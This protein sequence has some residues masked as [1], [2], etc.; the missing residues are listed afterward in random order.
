M[1]H[2]EALDVHLI[3]HRVRPRCS[4]CTIVGP[5]EVISD[6]DAA[7]NEGRGVGVVTNGVV[8]LDLV[9]EYCRVQIDDALDRS[10][11]RIEQQLV[12]IPA[13]SSP[14]IPGPVHPEAVALSGADPGQIPVPDAERGLGQLQPF[15]DAIVVEEAYLDSLGAA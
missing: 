6:D 14:G 2:G 13:C 9:A 5:V 3:D 7:G 12:W 4:G 11:V 15:L 1:L 8:A 10:T